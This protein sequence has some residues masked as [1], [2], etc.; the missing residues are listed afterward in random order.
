MVAVF[1]HVPL[2]DVRPVPHD[3]AQVPALHICPP[4]H[5]LPQVPQCAL[6]VSRFTQVPPH[7]ISPA[8]HITLLSGIM[9]TSC[10]GPE[11][12]PTPPS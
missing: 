8:G 6:L 9:P 11:S 4:V 2:H 7:T 3:E 12:R 5:A 10:A 1:T